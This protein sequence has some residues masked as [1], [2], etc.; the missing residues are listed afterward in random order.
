MP[1]SPLKQDSLE[2]IDEI[3]HYHKTEEVL[4][5]IENQV[6]QEQ[7]KNQMVLGQASQLTQE[8]KTIAEPKDEIL[9]ENA[10]WGDEEP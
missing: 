3:P 5:E 8:I 6:D 4:V 2:D 1:I 10:A 9:L 7:E